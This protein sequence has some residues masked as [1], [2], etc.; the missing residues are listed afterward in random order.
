MIRAADLH[1]LDK[2]AGGVGPGVPSYG[3]PAPGKKL[4]SSYAVEKSS[5]HCLHL[6][7]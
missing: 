5:M 7:E 6:N 3:L 1:V 4:V 2:V